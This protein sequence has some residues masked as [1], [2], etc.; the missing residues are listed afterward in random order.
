MKLMR[1]VVSYVEVGVEPEDVMS[2][3]EAARLLGL[4]NQAI[5]SAIA[6]GRL[7]EL[8][9]PGARNPRRDRRFVLRAEVEELAERQRLA[10]RLA[11]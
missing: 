8:V 10:I 7:T 3:N 1:R 2:L 4:R 11:E 5:V 9:D 6:R